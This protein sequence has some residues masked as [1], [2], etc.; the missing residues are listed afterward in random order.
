MECLECD[1]DT[2]TITIEPLEG[3]PIRPFIDEFLST[4]TPG[5]RIEYNITCWDCGWEE[6]RYLEVG[7]VSQN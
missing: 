1:D 3:N 6:D 4:A 7:T 5:D 2:G